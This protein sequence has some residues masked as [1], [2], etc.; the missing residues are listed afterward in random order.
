M[1]FKDFYKSCPN[2]NDL[3]ILE[4]FGDVEIIEKNI[5]QHGQK[6]YGR[7]LIFNSTHNITST[8][9][10]YKTPKGLAIVY[11]QR[12]ILLTCFK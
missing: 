3:Y 2:Y 1:T 7:V 8:N 4:Q 11:K 5:K 6:T 10:I 9:S 12:K